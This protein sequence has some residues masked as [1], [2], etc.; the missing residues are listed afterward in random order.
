MTPEQI[1]E[2]VRALDDL[3]TPEGVGLWWQ[4]WLRVTPANREHLA[5][6]IVAAA[7]GAFA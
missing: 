1:E 5:R 6:S 2:L 3:Y 7:D 4:N